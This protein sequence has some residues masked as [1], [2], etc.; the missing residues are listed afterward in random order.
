M[1]GGGGSGA[2][3][4]AAG[5][6]AAAAPRPRPRPP[7][8]RPPKVADWHR[9][10]RTRPAS[11]PHPPPPLHA[12][13]ATRPPTQPGS[14]TLAV[15]ADI[16][17]TSAAKPSHARAPVNSSAACSS[18]SRLLLPPPLASRPRP[19]DL[20]PPLPLLL[21]AA[22]S[23]SAA[24]MSCSRGT[25]GGSTSAA[26]GETRHFGHD[27]VRQL[28]AIPQNASYCTVLGQCNTNCEPHQA[29]TALN[30]VLI[31]LKLNIRFCHHLARLHSLRSHG[32]IAGLNSSL[33]GLILGQRFLS[34]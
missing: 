27:K 34:A 20:P 18:S 10:L 21:A 23:A 12:L 33:G 16:S 22:A 14:I 3:G 25:R 19:S 31:R 2:A 9:A 11:R 28:R 17:E 24:A 8:A 1:G 15:S 5:T 32:Q 4:A 26:S 30:I 7:R 6:H 13:L 29:D